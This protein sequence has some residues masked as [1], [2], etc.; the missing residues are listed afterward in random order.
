MNRA[1][2]TGVTGFLGSHLAE[3]L[4]GR[5]SAVKAVCRSS[6]SMGKV[7]GGCS[8][9][10]VDPLDP[11]G[12]ARAMEGAEVIYHI[13]GAT[14]AR[15][16]ED[17]DGSN[18]AVTRAMVAAW[19]RACPEALFVQLSSQS[20][21]GPCGGGPITPYGC[22]K[23][24]AEAVVRRSPGD[25][26][27]VRPPAVFGPRD[28]AMAPVFRMA[29]RG[30][31]LSP[32]SG[33]GFALVYVK[34][35]AR[36]LVDLPGCEGAR[37]VVLEPSY[38]RTFGWGE[39]HGYLEAA[40]GRSVLH[41][42]VPSPLV[43]AAAFLSETAGSLTGR[44]PVFDRHKGREFLADGWRCD[45]APVE[46]LTG[47]KASTPVENAVRETMEWCLSSAAG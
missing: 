5:G 3:A 17:F 31:F 9:E 40:A 33:G 20:A 47:W 38:G 35:L 46:E 23:L 4:M 19:R 36:L 22:S 39:F 24:M 44:C 7:P 28:D 27:I 26:V 41:I 16:Q 42:R 21:G 15:S 12:L 32:V 25:W 14:S 8:V 43:I 45:S 29:S 11:A 37:R 13:A 34:D 6:S 18:A 1:F 10:R 2:L 30:L